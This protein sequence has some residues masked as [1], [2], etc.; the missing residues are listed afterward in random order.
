MGVVAVLVQTRFELRHLSARRL[1][2]REH[3]GFRR[4]ELRGLRLRAV[5]NLAYLGILRYGWRL[6]CQRAE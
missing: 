2:Q 6:C 5:T 1:D 4:A 3:P